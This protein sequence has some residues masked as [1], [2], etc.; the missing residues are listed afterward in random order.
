MAAVC[1][2]RTPRCRHTSRARR[3]D[4][5]C[6][7]APAASTAASTANKIDGSI[8]TAYAGIGSAAHAARANQSEAARTELLIALAKPLP[9]KKRAAVLKQFLDG[10]TVWQADDWDRHWRAAASRPEVARAIAEGMTLAASDFVAGVHVPREAGE[11]LRD[12]PWPERRNDFL[13]FPMF[14]FCHATAAVAFALAG[15]ARPNER[16]VVLVSTLHATVLSLTSGT[17]VDF[18]SAAQGELRVTPHGGRAAASPRARLVPAREVEPGYVATCGIASLEQMVLR[19]ASGWA[20]YPTL[21]LYLPAVAASSPL[22]R[23]MPEWAQPRGCDRA[24]FERLV[25]SG[26]METAFVRGDAMHNVRF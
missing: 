2:A 21:E 7:V 15:A 6:E 10:V 23:P 9:P 12:L 13:A 25:A 22:V 24:R 14:G 26:A 18:A 20:A 8:A 17:L 16:W 1:V 19:E 4:A 11:Q 5:P 3:R